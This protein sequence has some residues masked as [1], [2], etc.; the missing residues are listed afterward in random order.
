MHTPNLIKA[1]FIYTVETLKDGVVIDREIVK[2]I[3][4]IE[5]LNHLIAVGFKAAAQYPTWY[6]GVYEG[7][8]S[9]TADDVMA[10]FPIT[11]TEL[12]AYV[13]STR[14]PLVLGDVAGGAVS[15]IL[16]KATITG[17]TDG[18]FAHGGFVCSAPAKGA[19]TGPLVSAVRFSSPKPLGAGMALNIT[20]GFTLTPNA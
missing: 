7:A 15:N 5:G 1:G 16:S 18:K 11:A 14:R 19:T 8:Y 4:P 2:N 6:I 13:E 10:T 20:A 17:T 9:P 3:I 12:T